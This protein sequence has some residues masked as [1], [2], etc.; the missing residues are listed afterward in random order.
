MNLAGL[1]FNHINTQIEAQ[2]T[3]VKIS[4]LDL[5]NQQKLIDNATEVQEFL[6]NKYTNDELYSYLENSMRT[7]L[8]QTYL[9]AYDLAKKAEQ[10][11]R[12]ER[13]PT[14][15]QDATDF[16]SFGYFNPARDGLQASQQ[17]YLALKSMD[18]AYQETRGH[19]YEITKAVSLR[20]L[21][22]YALLTLRETGSCTFDV[23]EVHFDM[24]F[25]GHFFRRIKTASLT[26]PCVVGPYVGVNATLRLV[27]HRY[28][29]DS[30]AG[31]ARDYVE[32][33]ESGQLDRRFR[34]GI[35]PID[36][37]ATSSAQNDSGAFEL[38]LK[39]ER[40]LPF[41]GAGA[42]STWQVMLPP[43]EFPPFDYSSIADVVLS[44]KY[45]SCEGGDSLRRAAA[46]SVVQ[47]IGS[48]EGQSKE[49]GLLALWDIKAEFAAEWAKLSGPAGGSNPAGGG[50]DVRAL[51]LKGLNG[52]LP[53]F[54]AGRDVSKVKAKDVSLVTNLGISQAAD[55]SIDFKYVAGGDGE[56]ETSFDSGPTKVGGS[57][58]MFRISEADDAIA[59]WA[60][61]VKISADIKVDTKSRMWIV[62]R[63][64]LLKA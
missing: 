27:K 4:N 17:L 20:Q 57:M 15:A 24:D 55:L 56:S 45:T 43:K 10:G 59:D 1:E 23:P 50:E 62:T 29:A 6:S 58:S 26:I 42:V 3:R 11:F 37:V 54:V 31:S 19:D 63:Y 18:V 30:L 46:E 53:S 35:I 2:E 33:T 41:E 60:L 47:W 44:L 22:P 5:A 32:D 12:F 14:S 48:V 36:A 21:N 9:L 49:V 61:K 25:P 8:Y 38:S 40:Y 52:R 7:S 64:V 51:V 13:R 16:I 34:S 28:R 39:D